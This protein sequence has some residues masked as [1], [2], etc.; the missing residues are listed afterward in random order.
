MATFTDKITL[1]FNIDGRQSSY[2]YSYDISSV[3]N[4]D[5]IEK[6]MGAQTGLDLASQ[7]TLVLAFNRAK[8]QKMSVYA[9]NNAGPTTLQSEFLN[10]G[11]VYNLHKAA[12]GG[13][14]NVSDTA[15][16]V[17]FLAVNSVI[18]LPQQAD[19]NADIYAL[20]T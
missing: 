20:F 5:V 2:Q 11:G 10:E 14:F 17:T 12:A 8:I 13:S 3:L 1:T 7:P 4:V 18:A 6:Q 9:V 16:T 19:N 15:S